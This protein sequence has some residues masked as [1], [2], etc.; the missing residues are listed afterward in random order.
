MPQNKIPVV[1]AIIFIAFMTIYSAWHDLSSDRQKLVKIRSVEERL[2]KIIKID[3]I[4]TE[5][6]K[7]RGLAAIS[8]ADPG[9]H[10]V[11]ALSDQRKNTMNLLNSFAKKL[12]IPVIERKYRHILNQT[13]TSNTA[14]TETFHNYTLLISQ[15]MQKSDILVFG[16]QNA[17]IKNSLFI[18]QLLN[19]ARENIDRLCSIIGAVFSSELLTDQNYQDII[20]LNALFKHQVMYAQSDQSS[21]LQPLLD[22][23]QHQDCVRKTL[24]VIQKMM[25]RSTDNIRLAP[26]DWFQRSTCTVAL[27]HDIANKR[28]ELIQTTLA[29]TANDAKSAMIRHLVFWSGCISALS[30]LLVIS[31]RR[32]KA[33]ARG[34]K[35]LEHYQDAIDYSTIVSK[36]DKQGIITYVNRAFCEISGFSPKELLHQPHNI[37]RHPDMPPEVFQVMWNDLKEGKKWNGIIKNLKKD[38][39]AYWVDASISPIYDHR[40]RLVEYIAIRRDITDMIL[41]NEEIKDTQRQL[42][43]RMGE[44]VESRSKESG[45]HIQRVAHYSRLLAQL[46]GLS[47][48]ECETIFAASTMHDIGKIS[49]SDAILLKEE[50]LNDEEWAVMKTHAE[51]GYKILEGSERPLL[52]MAATVAYEH[53]EHFNGN[54]YPRGIK[55]EEISIYGRIVA[56]ADVFDALATKRI[57]KQAW[58]LDAT[59]DYLKVQS[60]KQFDPEL[61]VLFVNY[62]DQFIEIKNRFRDNERF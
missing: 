55:G 57:Y 4:I 27:L 36:A 29:E 30:F 52:K 31:L 1:S 20:A 59:L 42:I 60:G 58:P 23:F 9:G 15:A 6:Q 8:N 61:I 17:E 7:E 46:A 3:A 49:I 18:Y 28:L 47:E 34:H 39:S 44:A 35:L 54:G 56:V 38:G 5:L 48:E 32:S 33:L 25:N 26:V 12:D 11:S 41:L 62:L 37:V 24:P 53:H 14:Q 21:L 13:E 22:D 2:Q 16:I 40:G 19:S 50:E 51:I 10:Y 45:H 43:Y